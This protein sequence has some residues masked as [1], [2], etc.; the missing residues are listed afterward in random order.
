MVTLTVLGVDLLRPRGAQEAASSAAA[1]LLGVG[2]LS[3]ILFAAFVAWRLLAP[4]P[5]FYRRGGLAV[6]ASFATV[7][8]MVA[9]VP[10]HQFYGRPGL[11]ALAGACVLGALVASQAARRAAQL[12]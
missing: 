8:M 2:T 5:S 9:A 6:V 11:Y 7:V 4:L 3:G 10:L 1:L 12:P